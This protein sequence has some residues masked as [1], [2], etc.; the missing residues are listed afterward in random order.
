MKKIIII[1]GILILTACAS[2]QRHCDA[3]GNVE[4]NKEENEC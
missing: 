4:D 1:G 2:N 3:Y